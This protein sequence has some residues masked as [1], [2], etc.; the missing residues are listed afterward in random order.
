MPLKS[1]PKR[2]AQCKQTLELDAAAMEGERCGCMIADAAQRN[3]AEKNLV[4][5]DVC[6]RMHED[7]IGTASSPGGANLHL[8][9]PA[10]K[11]SRRSTVTLEPVPKSAARSKFVAVQEKKGTCIGEG[12]T[13]ERWFAHRS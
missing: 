2:K 10:K 11:K 6:M 7:I 8:R 12:K 5:Q 3:S 4:S 13:N 9:E 1:P